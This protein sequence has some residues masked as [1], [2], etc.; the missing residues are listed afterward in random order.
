MNFYK[1]NRGLSKRFYNYFSKKA[2]E[3]ENR[4]EYKELN[5]YLKCRPLT[6]SQKKEIK[7]YYANF[8]FKNIS[9]VWHRYYTHLTGNFYKE[10]I[11]LDFF[12]NVIEPHLNMKIMFP[13]LTDKNILNKLFKGVELLEP[14]VKNINGIF[15]DGQDNIIIDFGNVL[16]K[17]KKYNKMVIKPSIDSGGG[18]NVI[19]FE[20]M[21]DL[22]DHKNLTLEELISSYDKNFIIQNYFIQ[23]EQMSKLNKSSVNTIRMETLLVNGNVEILNTFVRMGTEGSKIDNINSGG[24]YCFVNL[25]GIL[26]KNI[27]DAS[28]KLLS[29]TERKIKPE[30][31]KIPNF[32]RIQED[33]K[34]LHKQICHFRMVSWDITIDK[35]GKTVLIEFNVFGQ[36]IAQERGPV[37]GKFTDEILRYCQLNKLSY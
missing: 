34:K 16:K 17:C 4:H 22:T 26:S 25:D 15:L 8:G 32:N 18:N 27:F 19:V 3:Y 31:I 14:V 1:I 6:K 11:P 35:K 12:Y 28:G 23:H 7:D 10:Y 29:E 21:G 5:N 37:F 30:L 24:F 33:V 36:G 20:L 2:L 9:T 13:A